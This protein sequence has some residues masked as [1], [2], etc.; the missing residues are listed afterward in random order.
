MCR[1]MKC[2]SCLTDLERTYVHNVCGMTLCF[3]CLTDHIWAPKSVRELV[4]SELIQ[5]CGE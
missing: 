2:D 3:D 4:C 1:E 5:V